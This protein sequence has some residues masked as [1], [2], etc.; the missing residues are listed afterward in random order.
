MITYAYICD[1]CSIDSATKRN[2]HGDKFSIKGIRNKEDS[3]AGWNEHGDYVFYIDSTMADKPSHPACPKCSGVKTNSTVTENSGQ[4]YIRGNCYLDKTGA[5]RD[6]SVYKLKNEDPYGHMRVSGEVDHMVAK[7]KNM[8]RDMAMIKR[9][10]VERVNTMV[11]ELSKSSSAELASI[12]EVEKK[13]IKFIDVNDTA[14]NGIEFSNL[15]QEHDL[16]KIM[17]DLIKNG[18]VNVRKNGNFS[19]MAQGRWVADN[20]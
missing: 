17:T 1:D 7:F 8:G 6:Q 20:I 4:G 12:S 11:K 9:P 2:K 16:N 3:V 18:Y 5:K 15:P 14:R 19:L 10:H 13:I